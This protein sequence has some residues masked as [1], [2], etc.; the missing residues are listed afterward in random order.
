MRCKLFAFDI[1]RYTMRIVLIINNQKGDAYRK[2]LAQP[3]QLAMKPVTRIS[4]SRIQRPHVPG[5][6]F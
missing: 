5:R 1:Y 4:S 6:F 3:D 2:E